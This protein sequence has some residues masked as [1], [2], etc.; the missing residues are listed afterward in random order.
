MKHLEIFA[1]VADV[2]QLKEL[3]SE[4]AALRNE[5]GF[6]ISCQ[7]SVG[8][9]VYQSVPQRLQEDTDID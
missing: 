5:Y 3:L 6:T 9:S 8:T 2:H 4:L 1:S 7:I